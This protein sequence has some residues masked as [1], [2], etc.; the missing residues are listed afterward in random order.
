MREQRV[1][2]R[3]VMS[4]DNESSTVMTVLEKGPP[5]TAVQ[6][7]VNQALMFMRPDRLPQEKKEDGIKPLQEEK[8]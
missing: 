4:A 6:H 7:L 2:K 1:A 5:S 3:T 8:K